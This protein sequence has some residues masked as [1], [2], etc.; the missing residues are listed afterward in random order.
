ML[1]HGF[2][3]ERVPMETAPMAPTPTPRMPGIGIVN[4]SSCRT[5]IQHKMHDAEVVVA[6]RHLFRRYQARHF[7]PLLKSFGHDATIL[8]RSQQVSLG[9]E[10]LGDRSVR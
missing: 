2:I 10:V 8:T 3:P 6:C 7:P 9:P 1:C 4:L 5:L